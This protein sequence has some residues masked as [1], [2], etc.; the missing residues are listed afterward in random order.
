MLKDDVD[1]D[2]LALSQHSLLALQSFFTEREEQDAKFQLLQSQDDLGKAGVRDFDMNVNMNDFAEDW[3]YVVL[4][5]RLSLTSV[6]HFMCHLT[7][8]FL[9]LGC[10]SSGIIQIRQTVLLTKL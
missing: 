3:Q 7:K 6:Q 10:R 2:E 9:T 5:N 1:D 4:L 8:N